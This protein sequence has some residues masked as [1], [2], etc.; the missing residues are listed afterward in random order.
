MALPG[1]GVLRST[2]ACPLKSIN[3]LRSSTTNSVLCNILTSGGCPGDDNEHQPFLFFAADD[4][5]YQERNELPDVGFRA[6]V[7]IPEWHSRGRSWGLDRND[8]V[9][10]LS[11]ARSHDHY[12]TI[13]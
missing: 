5:E 9:S 8:Q 7:A 12:T 10:G 6:A 4:L 13:L 2:F 1:G 3:S 11:L